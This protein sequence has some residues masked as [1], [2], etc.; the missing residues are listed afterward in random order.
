MLSGDGIYPFANGAGITNVYA[1]ITN[2]WQDGQN[3]SNVFYPRL[4]N[5]EDRNRNNTQ[6]SSWWVRNTDFV[7]LK[8]LELSYNLPK[9]WYNG[10]FRNA[11]VYLQAI[12]PITFSKFKLWDVESTV[13]AGNGGRYPN[14]KSY[15]LGVTVD[16]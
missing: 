4:A 7:R 1:N 11:S 16:F 10:I 5:G 9:S 6:P 8:T 14:V 3:N 15:S 12:N 13:N 2:R